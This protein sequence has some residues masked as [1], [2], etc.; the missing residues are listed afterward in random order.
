MNNKSKVSTGIKANQSVANGRRPKRCHLCKKSFPP[1]KYV[2]QKLSRM[3]I[4]RIA[5]VLRIRK[6]KTTKYPN[7]ELSPKIPLTS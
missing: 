3:N 6:Y 2:N 1:D 7:I 5:I 4:F